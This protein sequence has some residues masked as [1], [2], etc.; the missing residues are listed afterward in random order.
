MKM[1]MKTLLVS[2]VMLLMPVAQAD[3]TPA[4]Y[5]VRHAEKQADSDP[6]LTEE[7]EARAEA[8]AA[9]LKKAGIE[10]VYSTPY[11]RTMMTAAPV[12][13]EARLSVKEYDPRKLQ[14]FADNLK[15]EFM[16]NPRPMLV[17]GH[18][19]TTPVLVNM[20]TGGTHRLLNEDEYNFLF[21]VRQNGEN[22]LGY[23]I[24]HF[25]P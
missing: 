10:V 12:A 13:D 16:E 9:L 24:E 8:L 17:V 18:S 7:G 5:L 2:A 23:T 3:E 21:V 14:E 19:N 1:I 22:A 11:K 20:L 6:A 25:E 15:K 4:I